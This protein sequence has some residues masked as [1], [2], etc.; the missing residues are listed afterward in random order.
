M[1]DG[2]LASLTEEWIA[3]QIR[4][5][6]EFADDDVEVF[7]GSQSLTAEQLIE[8]FMSHRSLYATTWYSGDREVELEEGDVAYDATYAVLVVVQNARP[9]EARKGGADGSKGTNY[10]RD[11]LRNA[12]NSGTTSPGLSANGYAVDWCKWTGKV[13]VVQ[14][15]NAYI[16]RGTVVVRESPTG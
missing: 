12:L 2:S 10:F 7:T 13:D 11:K 6:A 4:A 15:K 16:M 3:V 14:K 8:Q 9:G 1:N 5:L